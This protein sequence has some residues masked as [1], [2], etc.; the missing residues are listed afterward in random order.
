MR[1]RDSDD[2]Y[3]VW[4]CRVCNFE[5]WRNRYPHTG[6]TGERNGSWV[7]LAHDSDGSFAVLSIWPLSSHNGW[8]KGHQLSALS[9]RGLISYDTEMSATQT[10]DRC[11]ILRR[12]LMRKS[13][14]ARYP[15]LWCRE[16]QLTDNACALQRI[17]RKVGG[18]SSAGNRERTPGYS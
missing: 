18:S 4:G 2:L 5:L 10:S 13:S 3:R 17:S 16:F 12:N 7:S 11:V 8:W 1:G 14:E 6:E 9:R 15:G